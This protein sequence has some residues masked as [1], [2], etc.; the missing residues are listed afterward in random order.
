[1]HTTWIYARESLARIEMEYIR[2]FFRES[3]RHFKQKLSELQAQ[4]QAEERD[5]PLSEDAVDHYVDLRDEIE[6]FGQLNRYFAIAQAYSIME[7]AFASII[8]DAI[9]EGTLAGDDWARVRSR[10]PDAA[11]FKRGFRSLRIVLSPQDA[12]AW[13]ALGKKRNIILHRSGRFEVHQGGFVQ[14]RQL[15]FTEAEVEAALDMALR[16]A[17]SALRQYRALRTAPGAGPSR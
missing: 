1:M 16:C 5:A 8:T 9:D 3:D 12:S 17:Q 2:N 4:A 15:E 11:S 10:F 13:P 6:G 14:I 7:Q